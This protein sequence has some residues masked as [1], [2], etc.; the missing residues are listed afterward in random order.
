[1]TPPSSKSREKALAAWRDTAPHHT[2][3]PMTVQ[4]QQHERVPQQQRLLQQR[5]SMPPRQ[6]C[7]TA[8]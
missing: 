1:M 6:D 2:S 3:G 4:Q 8:A 5:G 7:D